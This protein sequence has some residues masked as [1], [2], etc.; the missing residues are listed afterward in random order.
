[1]ARLTFRNF[2]GPLFHLCSC[3]CPEFALPLFIWLNCGWMGLFL[4]G[5][6]GFRA[7]CPAGNT[8]NR[9]AERGLAA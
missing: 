3:I 8:T 5:Q 4:H 7:A 6:A 2:P 9:H 1:M